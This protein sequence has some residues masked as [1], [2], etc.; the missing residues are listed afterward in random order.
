MSDSS[1]RIVHNPSESRYE[2]FVGEELATVADYRA[3]GRRRVFN[4]TET[5]P[6]FRGQG[7]AEKIVAFALD[8]VKEK[9][10]L[11]YPACWFVAD[12][13]AAHPEYRDLVA[14]RRAS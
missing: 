13:V 10:L 11:I 2:L 3:D 1:I 12:F 8:D 7:L 5:L 6:R 4:H 9:G 14:D